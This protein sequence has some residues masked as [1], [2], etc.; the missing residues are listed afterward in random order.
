MTKTA[1]LFAPGRRSLLGKGI[2]SRSATRGRRGFW[3]ISPFSL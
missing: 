2:E 1:F 3:M